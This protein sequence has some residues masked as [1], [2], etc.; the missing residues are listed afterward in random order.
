MQF[1]DSLLVTLIG[2]VTV[3]VGLVILIGLIV[4]VAK[5][6]G[7]KKP[8]QKEVKEAPAAPA[9]VAAAPAQETADDLRLIAVITAAVAAA[10]ED[11]AAFTVRRVRRVSNAS[12]WGNAGR[13]DQIFSRL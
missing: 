7:A 6:T 9:P 5:L 4:V 8:A 1:G 13:E 2:M 10:M 12:A 11:G 3:F